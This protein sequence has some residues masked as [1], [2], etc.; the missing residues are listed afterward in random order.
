MK[1][2]IVS[3]LLGSLGVVVFSA[4]LAFPKS[5]TD[6][7]YFNPFLLNG[8]PMDLTR[9]T[10]STSGV[11]SLVKND[12]AAA[13]AAQVPFLI[14][15][16]RAGKIVDASAYAHNHAVTE[17]EIAT[18]LRGAQP[19]DELVV[20]PTSEEIGQRTITVKQPLYAPYMPWFFGA[21]KGKDGC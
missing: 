4:F 20:D 5:H 18:V 1:N 15:L 12:P 11:L 3:L 14:Y 8:K 17:I 6:S 2:K 21:N 19:G 16:R 13:P 10:T 7:F 9:L